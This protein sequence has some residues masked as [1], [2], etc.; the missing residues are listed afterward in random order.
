MKHRKIYRHKEKFLRQK[1]SCILL[2]DYLDIGLLVLSL[3][4]FSLNYNWVKTS[5]VCPGSSDPT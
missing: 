2:L 1:I 4:S 3:L 5:T